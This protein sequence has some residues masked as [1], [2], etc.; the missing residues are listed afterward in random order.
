LKKIITRNICFLILLF[1]SNLSYALSISI[2]ENCRDGANPFTFLTYSNHLVDKNYKINISAYPSNPDIIFRK[3][4]DKL[5]ADIIIQDF[6]NQSES[7]R[8]DSNLNVCRSNKGK[9]IGFS[10]FY[11]EPDLTIQI[12][13][14]IEKYDYSIY[15]DSTLFTIEEGLAIILTPNI[16]LLIKTTKKIL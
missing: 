8:S 7:E 15:Y 16:D 5:N 3:V 13:N 4:K 14:F 12:S 10:K 11:F 1:S 6:S 2:E 9:L